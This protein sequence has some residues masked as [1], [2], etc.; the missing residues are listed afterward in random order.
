M[1]TRTRGPRPRPRP[2]TRNVNVN[3]FTGLFTS[4][5]MFMFCE[6]YCVRV[7][8]PVLTAF[9]LF[10]NKWMYYCYYWQTDSSQRRMPNTQKM[11]ILTK[12]AMHTVYDH[13][14]Q[15]KME[16]F[17]NTSDSSILSDIS[18][19]LA[20]DKPLLEKTLSTGA[21]LAGTTKILS[22][23]YPSGTNFIWL[24]MSASLVSLSN[25]K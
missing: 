2:R 7:L 24:Q 17:A 11:T 25:N 6:C 16:H 21:E 10:M 12:L 19:V 22:N 18:A 3:F 5:L 8:I 4:F 1:L 23:K 14:S 13:N 20:D 15:V 9:C